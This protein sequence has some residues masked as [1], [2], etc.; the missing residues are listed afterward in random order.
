[1]ELKPKVVVWI[2]AGLVLALATLWWVA[3]QSEE[4]SLTLGSHPTGKVSVA[5]ESEHATGF[6]RFLPG[7]FK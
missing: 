3:R 4:G 7:V 2:G 6:D 1:M 5:S